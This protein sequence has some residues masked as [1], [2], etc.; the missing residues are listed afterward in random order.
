MPNKRE[1]QNVVQWIPDPEMDILE[2]EERCRKA[3]KTIVR[4]IFTRIL[5]LVILCWAV[6]SKEFAIWSAGLVLF[7]LVISL[8]GLLPLGA[9]LKKRRAELKQI[10]QEAE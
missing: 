7:V 9:E 3:I 1:N 4:A 5:V 2:R 10:I 8:S 6:F